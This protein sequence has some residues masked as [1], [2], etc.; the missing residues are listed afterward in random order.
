MRYL[1]YVK[2]IRKNADLLKLS[3][4]EK[5]ARTTVGLLAKVKQG[6]QEYMSHGDVRSLEKV[7]RQLKTDIEQLGI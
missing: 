3:A 7:L 5:K 1:K 4:L 6:S 2:F